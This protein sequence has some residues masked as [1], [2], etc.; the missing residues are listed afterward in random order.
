MLALSRK[1]GQSITM[2]DIVVYISKVSGN[3]VTLAIQ[4]PDSVRVLRTEGLP[5]S[6]KVEPLRAVGEVK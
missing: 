4:A 6:V 3:R 2:G 5:D 1:P